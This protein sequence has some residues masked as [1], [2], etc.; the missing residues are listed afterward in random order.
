MVD[1]ERQ[2][3]NGLAERLRPAKSDREAMLA[4]KGRMKRA[5]DR[6]EIADFVGAALALKSVNALNQ[7]YIRRLGWALMTQRRFAE[8]AEAFVGV[9][10]DDHFRW[11]DEA[12]ALAGV[13]RLPEASAAVVICLERL[14]DLRADLDS[15]ALMRLLERRLSPLDR[16]AGWSAARARTTQAR[17][18]GLDHAAIT[19]IRDFLHR[20]AELLRDAIET[21]SED[22]AAVSGQAALRRAKAML[23]LDRDE[24]AA[25]SLCAIGPWEASAGSATELAPLLAAAAAAA[26]PSAQPDLVQAL[27]AASAPGPQREFA[28]LVLR[29]LARAAPWKDLTTTACPSR[30]AGVMAAT[31]LARAG[32]VR[33]AIVILGLLSRDKRGEPSRR[34]LAACISQET[35]AR[36]GFRTESRSGP[37]RVFDLFPYNGELELLK[38]KLHEMAAWVERFVIVE[39]EVTFTGRPKRLT[40]DTAR[41]E[42]GPFLPK[43]TYV[44]IRQFPDHVASP[45]A[46]EFHQRD[47]AIKALQGLCAPDDILLLTDADEVICQSAVERFCGEAAPVA[48]LFYR[49]FLNHMAPAQHGNASIWRARHLERWGSSYARTVLTGLLWNSRIADA[50]WHFTSVGGAAA[51][52]RKLSSY[53]HEEND[54]PDAEVHYAEVLERLRA[55]DLEP[56]WERCTLERLP[57]YVRAH[58]E[59]FA[60][61]LL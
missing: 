12:R 52:A 60:N 44:V 28:E 58:R 36:L 34:D 2:L 57:A 41:A 29:V 10:E 32:Q 20:R 46:R 30:E 33:A 38:I 9:Q 55:G 53:A 17:A 26:P 24:E 54:R 4:L 42:I 3:S 35:N 13:G 56:G 23:L 1:F 16:A 22:G 43:I 45:W 31:A 51:I 40:F 11:F 21:A 14:D 49:F 39:S 5:W 25:A 8:A 47:Q 15:K 6:N 18:S 7:N 37:P 61:L 27:A 19:A 48:M 50:G 59:E